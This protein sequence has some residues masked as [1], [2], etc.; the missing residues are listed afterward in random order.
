[1]VKI[2]QFS[3]MSTQEKAKVKN[4]KVNVPP[5]PKGNQRATKFDTPEKRQ[6]LC[7]KWC[8]HMRMGCTKESFEEC[9]PQ[10]FRRYVK[11]FPSDFDIDAIN[12]AERGGRLKWEKWG[13]GGTLGQI[14][15]FNSSCYKFNVSNRYG[16]VEKQQLSNDPENPMPASSVVILPDNGRTYRK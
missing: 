5:A 13:I 12:A 2:F 6:K 15:N 8:A 4:P 14:K 10:T 3:T 1:M 16:W 9:D 7:E 11:D